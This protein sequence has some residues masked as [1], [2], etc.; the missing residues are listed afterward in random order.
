MGSP[1]TVNCPVTGCVVAASAVPANPGCLPPTDRVNTPGSITRRVSSVIMESSRGSIVKET[2]FDDPA[3]SVIRLNPT[4]LRIGTGTEAS[5]S[6]IYIWTT[7][8][9]ALAPV[10]DTV[11]DTLTG[12]PAATDSGTSRLL[13]AN[14]V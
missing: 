8:S 2:F 6:E 3:S 10:L 1:V 4:S 13:Y 11:T 14:V 5:R 7:S 12:L 9:P